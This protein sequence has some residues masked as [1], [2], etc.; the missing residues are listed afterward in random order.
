MRL[1]KILGII[2][3]VVII[4]L[5]VMIAFT[6]PK[7]YLE[8]SLVMNASPG[9]IYE[10]VNTFKD[11]SQWSPLYTMDPQVRLSFEGPD[12]GPGAKVQW[13]G[14]KA[15]SGSEYIIASEANRHVKKRLE[16]DGLNGIFYTDF[17]LQPVNGGT[18][19]IWS[20]Q[21][22]YAGTGVLNRVKG[23]L[24]NWF[25]D[26]LIGSRYEQGL[27]SLKKIVEDRPVF[28]VKITEEKA[29][30]FL[31]IG[32]QRTMNPEH[33]KAINQEKNA[34]YRDIKTL[35]KKMKVEQ[36]GAPLCV[37]TRFS[38]SNMDMICGLPIHENI[39]IDNPKFRVLKTTGGKVVKAIHLGSHSSLRD[40]HRQIMQY[41][42][43]KRLPVT[44]PSWE[45]YVTDFS[46]EK[47]T[48]RWITEIYYPID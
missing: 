37:Y 7:K 40:T 45:I 10:E 23:K 14:E 13:N 17:D 29:S 32:E 2:I 35:L 6:P 22:D 39:K 18:K 47:D 15:G 30:P 33:I 46:T 27:M 1:L 5:V 28:S 26:K 16:F 42:G 19:V 12:N 24:F 36:A 41:L 43:Y 38:E 34:I 8:R 3:S 48:A 44:G 25:A 11:F 20:Y 4:L 9:T 31:Y 21:A